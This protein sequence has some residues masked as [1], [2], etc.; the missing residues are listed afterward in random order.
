MSPMSMPGHREPEVDDTIGRTPTAIKWARGRSM[1]APGS[2]TGRS[3]TAPAVP[4]SNRVPGAD[5]R[6]HLITHRNP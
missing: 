2:V 4:E 6:P 5:A 3:G 1:A